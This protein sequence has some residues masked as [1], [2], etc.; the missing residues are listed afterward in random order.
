MPK[1][2]EKTK[3]TVNVDTAVNSYRDTA[4][5]FKTN[6]ISDVNKAFSDGTF[7]LQS[8][9]EKT[10]FLSLLSSLIDVHQANGHELFT[11]QVK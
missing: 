7:E 9:I 10:R 11:R 6:I 4:A 5:I 2:K 1:S 3:K 8:E